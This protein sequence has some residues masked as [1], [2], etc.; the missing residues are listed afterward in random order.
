MDENK[1][2]SNQVEEQELPVAED[3][4]GKNEEQ[5]NGNESDTGEDATEKLKAE[6]DEAK[7]KYL[8]LYSEFDN[9]RRRTSKERLELI[10]TA[11]EDLMAAMLPIIDD[12]ERADKAFDEKGDIKSFKKGYD[13]IYI[14]LKN[15]TESKGLKPMEVKAGDDFNPEVHEA[16]TQI[17]APEEKLKGKIVDVIESGYLLNDKVIRF[18]KVVTGA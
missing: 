9:Y 5:E 4:K 15:I 3:V 6:L 11:N 18:A 2:E 16:V 17:P 1:Q 13:L 7:E 14:K 8:R 12:L 10:S